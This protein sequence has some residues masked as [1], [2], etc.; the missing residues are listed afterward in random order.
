VFASASSQHAITWLVQERGFEYRHAAFLSAIVLLVAG[1]AGNLGIGALTDHAQRRHPAARLVSL[2]F[3]GALGLGAGAV[4]YQVPA[5]STLFLPAWFVATAWLLGWYG[6]L[7]ATVDEMAPPGLR[8]SVLGVALLLINVVGVASG[9]YV[10]GLLGD[11]LGLSAGLSFSL[12]PAAAGV[13][14]LGGVG[15]ARLRS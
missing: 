1:V 2:A 8:A 7:L 11:R 6:P 15:L 4:F 10:T 14:L 5:A 12:V 3:L 13:V 9:P